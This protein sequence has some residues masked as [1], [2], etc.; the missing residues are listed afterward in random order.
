MTIITLTPASS[1]LLTALKC[2]GRV[3]GYDT[4]IATIT[5]VS[6]GKWEGTTD[7]DESFTIIGG[8]ES[9][10]ASNEWFV[11][12]PEHLGD[13]WLPCNSAVQALLIIVEA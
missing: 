8:R 4:R 11:N 10:G 7:Y 3:V 12:W 1:G 9:G 2:N 6:A 5:K 13:R